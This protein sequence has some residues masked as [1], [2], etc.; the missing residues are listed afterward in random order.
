MDFGMCQS[1]VQED[2]GT[3]SDKDNVVQI[4]SDV[5]RK[6]TMS[7]N[8]ES[9]FPNPIVFTWLYSVPVY[10]F[11]ILRKVNICDSGLGGVGERKFCTWDYFRKMETIRRCNNVSS[12]SFWFVSR[13]L[14]TSLPLTH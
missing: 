5:R 8:L 7:G 1:L 6:F 9:K 2:W 10:N 4:T 13:I 14:R 3:C 12:S 11:E